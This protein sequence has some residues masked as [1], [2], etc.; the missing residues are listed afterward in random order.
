VTAAA[1]ATRT[2]Q[3]PVTSSAVHR[4]PVWVGVVTAARCMKADKEKLTDRKKPVS[5]LPGA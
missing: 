3:R 4:A 2:R 5:L 1:S